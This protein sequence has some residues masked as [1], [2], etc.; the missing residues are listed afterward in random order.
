MNVIVMYC[1]Y[2]VMKTDPLAQHMRTALHLS[3][4]KVDFE[5]K[6]HPPFSVLQD[7]PI[8]SHIL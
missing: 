6:T 8:Q 3:T 1:K 7:C 4:P 5:N 2:V